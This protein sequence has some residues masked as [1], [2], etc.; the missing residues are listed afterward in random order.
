MIKHRICLGMAVLIL[1][2]SCSDKK[3]LYTDEPVETL[4]KVAQDAYDQKN[5]KKSAEAFA[6]VE[7]QHPYSDMAVKALLMS[8]NSHY[9]A[10]KYQEAIDSYTVFISLHPSHADVAYAYYMIGLCH[11]E[12]IPIVERDQQPTQEALKAFDEVVNRFPQSQY[13]KDATFKIDFIKNHLAG[14]E[15]DVGRF[16]LNKMS[17][18]AAINRFKRVVDVFGTTS[19]T[20]E[21]LHRLTE[22][23]V[24]I[25]LMDQAKSSASVLG[26][27]YPNSSWY[28]NSYRL[29]GS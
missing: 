24:A 15:M 3:E 8:A 4:Y 21:A 18:I 9:E 13:S 1:V 17:Y 28:A 12:Q 19:H 26:H 27:N 16:Y 7:R 11:Y 14:K 6:E 20:P 5:Y 22:C 2:T 25:G 29:L 10:K 23:Y